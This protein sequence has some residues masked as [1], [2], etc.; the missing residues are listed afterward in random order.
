M[1]KVR[2]AVFPV[3]GLGTRFLPA[4]KATPKEMLPVVDKPLIQYAVEEA[5]EAGIETFVFVTGRGKTAIEDHFDMNYELESVLKERGDDRKLNSVTDFR[6]NSGEIVYVR[7]VR[8]EGLGHAVWCARHAIGDDSFAVILADDLLLPSGLALR[9]MIEEHERTG[10]NVVLVQDVDPADTGKY[11]IVTPGGATDTATVVSD[12][13]E[14]PSP[15]DAPSTLGVIGRYVFHRSMM[16][17]LASTGRGT[18]D[19]IQLTDAMAASLSSRPLHAVT[20]P[21]RRYDCGTKLGM[22]EATVTVALERD[23][24]VDDATTVIRQALEAG[25]DRRQ[26]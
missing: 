11:G 18:G 10:A 8:P 26:T 22:L 24:L 19:E 12:I 25:T 3:A 13:V 23:D 1:T 14:K 4:T 6:P 2:T 21:G 7:Q 17:E 5:A 20:N 9:S 15:E 16:D